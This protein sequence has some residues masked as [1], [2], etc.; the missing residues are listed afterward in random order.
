[1]PLNLFRLQVTPADCDAQCDRFEV[2]LFEAV[3]GPLAGSASP[4]LRYEE[5]RLT[6][7]EAPHVV[8][9]HADQQALCH[10][11]MLHPERFGQD[12]AFTRHFDLLR[13]RL[14][15]KFL[16]AFQRERLLPLLQNDE[17]LR[18]EVDA[19][20]SASLLPWEGLI[21]WPIDWKGKVD[22][23]PAERERW[24]LVRR[25]FDQSE[26]EASH[27]PA[28]R[29]ALVIVG[30]ARQGKAEN[31][32]DHDV[33]RIVE[34]VRS[35]GF[36]QVDVCSGRW[37]VGRGAGA[38]PIAPEFHLRRAGQIEELLKQHR[39]SIVHFVGHSDADPAFTQAHG[40]ASLVLEMQEQPGGKA[41]EAL[42]ELEPLGTWLGAAKVRLVVLNACATRELVA[43]KLLPHVEHV[44][45][46]GAIVPTELCLHWASA[47]YGALREGEASLP[48]AVRLGRRAVRRHAPLLAWI[49]QH[50]ARNDGRLS[51]AGEA[52]M[53]I[54]RYCDWLRL[55]LASFE[56]RFRNRWGRAMATVH[57][58]LDVGRGETGASRPDGTVDP[59]RPLVAD[60]LPRGA[61]V[62]F[63]ELLAQDSGWFLLGGGPGSGKSTT[64]RMHALQ[65]ASD[66][67]RRRVPI[68]VTLSEWLRDP[69]K[70]LSLQDFVAERARV[71]IADELDRLGKN[72]EL[73]VLLDGL[74]E[75]NPAQRLRLDEEIRQLE[76]HWHASR[77]VVSSRRYR[78]I[79]GLS[80]GFRDADILDLEPELA[81][82][83][84]K[85]LLAEIPETRARAEA[86]ALIWRARFASEV[87]SWREFGKVPLFVTLIADLIASGEEPAETRHGLFDQVLA[88]LCRD[89][90]KDHGQRPLLLPGKQA[91]GW[92]AL[93]RL[94]GHSALRMT[95]AHTILASREQ[96]LAC[97]GERRRD[98]R[99]ALS[100]TG[101]DS[102]ATLLE[103][104]AERSLILGP[105]SNE[106]QSPWR[107]WH[108]SFQEACAARELHARFFGLGERLGVRRTL[109]F[110]DGVIARSRV[111]ACFSLLG[112]RRQRRFRPSEAEIAK[113]ELG[114]V[115]RVASDEGL[116]GFF[117]EW[118]NTASA[119]D[120]G[121]MHRIATSG[122]PGL[123]LLRATVARLAAP[124][125]AVRIQ[126]D[127]WTETLALLAE[128]LRS[129]G[130]LIRGLLARDATLAQRCA[131]R[132]TRLDA[133]S[134]LALI[135]RPSVA[136]ERSHTTKD[137][138]ELWSLRTNAVHE[139]AA[140]YGAARGIVGD[141]S[142]LIRVLRERSTRVDEAGEL[143]LICEALDGIAARGHAKAAAACDEILEALP[144]PTVEQWR[145]AFQ[146]VPG[147]GVPAWPLVHAG[148][149]PMGA[150]L[151][152]DEQPQHRVRISQAFRIGA[153]AV[154]VAQFRLFW[155]RH[156][157][158]RGQEVLELS[159]EFD[160][161]PVNNV[162]WY[163]AQM[164]C[165]WLD[166]R[167]NALRAAV[168]ALAEVQEARLPSEAEWE[169]AAR[170][171]TS[172]EFWFGDAEDDLPSH[173]WFSGN[174]G[175]M[176]QPVASRRGGGADRS[177]G[178]L[179][180]AN[181]FGLFDVHGNVWEWCEDWFGPYP[182]DGAP[183]V[184]PRGP[185]QGS[186]RVLR[187]GS[188]NNR[189]AVCR[190]ACRV[191]FD[192]ALASVDVGFRVVLALVRSRARG[193]G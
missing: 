192:P 6:P 55:D 189:A 66:P 64:L 160:S 34:A 73:T 5:L 2:R 30:S 36:E 161:L 162:S 41:E 191:R 61:R 62:R 18:I 67:F 104:I 127:H 72:G 159:A 10:S 88:S 31:A 40:A 57:V 145:A 179:A 90:H 106:A 163:A 193:P 74:D 167:L 129:P 86:I 108:R 121:E 184:D 63:A 151:F 16:S 102:A 69:A 113:A 169:Y 38:L 130:A 79:R 85:R 48:D 164:F 11:A 101:C 59:A 143:W 77:V 87:R 23:A 190:S 3:V 147:R 14:W 117:R 84:L 100:A 131:L 94:L 148:E 42:L 92:P 33:K 96:I 171:G 17:H 141:T 37:Q 123:D 27:E 114:I 15:N 21:R 80:G 47:F 82:E 105:L 181:A 70:P 155:P 68:F 124:S 76:Q 75:I 7:D 152:A 144:H 50:W 71:G 22:D 43:Q 132:C 174:A 78:L 65:V 122:E 180:G 98:L 138:D 182:A 46:M 150:S 32:A 4:E 20:G 12:Q 139:R 13:R 53:R 172:T 116:E 107:F 126:Q 25:P 8:R 157:I 83:L 111:V 133:R 170:A 153:S 140:L 51:F 28:L 35:S 149:F 112:L 154:T 136:I 39:Y 1:M 97:F 173:G 125:E 110:L 142:D 134:W 115:E 168:P 135:E 109:A 120:R 45:S 176:T 165:R 178:E 118:V 91:M 99:G 95:Q 166:A 103:H 188:W 158:A 137:R 9:L 128:Q 29:R 81:A 26:A 24:E 44:V 93:L 177:R 185:D 58:E 60:A 56:G 187:G 52:R 49:P 89:E 175:G 156:R 183:R 119:A 19:R 146:T 186:A 54:E